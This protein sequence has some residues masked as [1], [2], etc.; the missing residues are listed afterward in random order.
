MGRRATLKPL[1]SGLSSEASG[2]SPT[3]RSQRRRASSR[4]CVAIT[5]WSSFCTFI[6][7]SLIAACF[8][9]VERSRELHEDAAAGLRMEEADHPGKALAVFLVDHVDGF[10]LQL[11]EVAVDVGSLKADVVQPLTLAR[12]EL[13][14][15]RFGAGRLQGLDLADRE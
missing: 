9:D 1:P 7:I 8:V 11:L 15:V 5:T 10:G 6:A 4:S 3:L 12:Q 2:L 13:R 14:H